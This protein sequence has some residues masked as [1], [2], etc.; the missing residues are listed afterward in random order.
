MQI[1]LV[2]DSQDSFVIF[3]R[4]IWERSLIVKQKF[5]NK[6]TITLIKQLVGYT[7]TVC[8]FR[9]SVYSKNQMQSIE[10]Q[11]NLNQLLSV[12]VTVAIY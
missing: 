7:F 5:F 9:H 8:L 12:N 1:E 2:Q 4:N 6:L 11:M 10:M 3:C